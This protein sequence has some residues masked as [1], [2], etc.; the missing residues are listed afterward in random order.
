MFPGT[1]RYSGITLLK[2]VTRQD[3]D[4]SHLRTLLPLHRTS[5][6]SHLVLP[7]CLSVPHYLL[8]SSIRGG[9]HRAGEDDSSWQTN[10]TANSKRH[11][12]LAKPSISAKS[13]RFSGSTI[14]PK[15]QCF[16]MCGEMPSAKTSG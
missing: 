12:S 3:A 14:R 10:S 5:C 6:R 9:T 1:Q 4:R 11:F 2:S 7:F 15:S 13:A 16:P 8:R